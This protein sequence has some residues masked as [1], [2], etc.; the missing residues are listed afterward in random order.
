MAT[1][2][3]VVLPDDIGTTIVLGAKTA[4]KYDVSLTELGLDTALI[5]LDLKGT[6]LTATSLNGT[7]VIDLSSSLPKIA[8][9]VF[10]KNVERVS[11]TLKFTVG[12]KDNAANDTVFTI[13][14]ADLLPVQ[15]DGETISGTGTTTDKLSVKIS[16]NAG[17]LLKQTSNGLVVS[18]SDIKSLIPASPARTIRL[19][20][21]TGETVVGYIHATEQ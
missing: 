20:N 9:D 21:A 12:E 15:T 14:V 18:S 19:V 10:L 13:D 7:K 16:S 1:D 11:N 17:N 8:A 4:G 6:T 5:G 2:L 3:R